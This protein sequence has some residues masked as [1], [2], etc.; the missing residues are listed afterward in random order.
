MSSG[1]PDL[2]CNIDRK[3]IA[4]RQRAALLSRGGLVF[5]ACANAV[6]ARVNA[7]HRAGDLGWGTLSLWA[8]I[9][10]SSISS[11]IIQAQVDEK[12]CVRHGLMQTQEEG[13]ESTK[14][15]RINDATKAS[16]LYWKSVRMISR[17]TVL[18]M[19]L[20]LAIIA[21]PYTL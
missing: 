1:D 12:T 20:G 14:A 4:R 11:F 8:M 3:G 5:L 18:G 10:L 13:P 2:A 6:N 21:A 9:V 15:V 7:A 19:G 16:L 17:G